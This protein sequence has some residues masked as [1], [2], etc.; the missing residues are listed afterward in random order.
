LFSR[1][2]PPLY[3]YEERTCYSSR[4]SSPLLRAALCVL[5][6]PVQ[7]KCLTVICYLG[8]LVPK[9]VVLLVDYAIK[10]IDER[11]WERARIK[12]IRQKVR[13]SH[14]MKCLIE[15]WV[16]GEIEIDRDKSKGRSEPDDC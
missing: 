15:M 14:V 6:G 11:L 13:M 8:I 12:A 4:E 10:G 1:R 7:R 9:G 3:G 2:Y 16:K 5:D